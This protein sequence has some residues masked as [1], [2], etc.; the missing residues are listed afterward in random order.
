MRYL[1]FLLTVM[2]TLTAFEQKTDISLEYISYAKYQNELVTAGTSD[3]EFTNSYFDTNLE[4]EY[5][6]SSEYAGRRYLQL[7]EL[8]ITKELEDYSLSIGKSIKQWGELEGFNIAD[9]YNQKNYIK[10]PFDKDAKY[11]AI[12]ADVT[13]YFDNDAFIV[14][15]KLYEKDMKYPQKS[16]PY[17]PFGREYD[18]TLKSAHSR[19]QPS[20]YLMYDCM[21]EQFVESETRVLFYHGYDNKRAFVLRNPTTLQQY[22]YSVNKYLLLSHVV[23]QDMIF[24][25]ELAYTNVIDDTLMS[26]YTQ[27]TFGV[28]K[29]FY[30]ISQTDITLYVEYYRYLY[31]DDTKMKNVDISEIYNNDVFM[32]LK[33]SLN[34]VRSS[35]VKAGVLYD[36]G[37]SEKVYKAELKSRVYGNFMMSGEYLQTISSTSTLLSHIGD[38]TR[39]KA[40]VSYSF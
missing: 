26:D 3:V 6:Y 16:E 13:R 40:N 15:L 38:T 10:D 2:S 9:I 19:Y 31:S 37:N 18:S 34:D 11:G 21:T 7:N 32:A 28:E 36:L 12:G 25:S 5:L 27:L 20:F 14:G 35:E 1:P 23:F 8:Y 33:F 17:A 24:K 30:D 39:I 4:V 29:S 22:A